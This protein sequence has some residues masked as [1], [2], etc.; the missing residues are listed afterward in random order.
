[1][2]VPGLKGGRAPILLLVVA[3]VQLELWWYGVHKCLMSNKGVKSTTVFV[4]VK[5]CMFILVTS[6]D[7]QTFLQPFAYANIHNILAD[8]INF[9]QMQTYRWSPSV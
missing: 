5:W 2:D 1:M 8:I 9:F 4:L 3:S 7:T 6:G